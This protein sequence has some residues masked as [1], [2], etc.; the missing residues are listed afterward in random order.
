MIIDDIEDLIDLLD[1]VS[2]YVTSIRLRQLPSHIS[3][4]IIISKLKNLA[5]LSIH[6]SFVLFPLLH[7]IFTFISGQSVL[8]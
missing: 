1:V 6:Y 7:T 2:P 8:E 4:Q 5:S 3:P